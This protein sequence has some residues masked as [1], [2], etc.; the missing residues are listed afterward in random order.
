MV[1]ELF[2]DFFPNA[3]DQIN[4]FTENILPVKSDLLSQNWDAQTKTWI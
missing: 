1:K 4:R 2:I 3:N